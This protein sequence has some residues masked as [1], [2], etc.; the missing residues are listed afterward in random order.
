MENILLEFGG[1]SYPARFIDLENE[2]NA[3][4]SVEELNDALMKDGQYVSSEAKELDERIRYF[5]PANKFDYSDE[6]LGEYIM[7]SEDSSFVDSKFTLARSQEVTACILAELIK[8]DIIP[9]DDTLDCEGLSRENWYIS[10]KRYLNLMYDAFWR[11]VESTTKGWYEYLL[12][13]VGLKQ[14]EIDILELKGCLKQ[15]ASIRKKVA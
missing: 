2:E 3:L 11:N 6:D 9:E 10:I 5:V 12:I 4:I 8:A 13:E 15:P 14:I 1:V 7:V